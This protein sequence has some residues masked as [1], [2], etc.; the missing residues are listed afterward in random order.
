MIA[1]AAG[2]QIGGQNAVDGRFVLD[3]VEDRDLVA[4]GVERNWISDFIESG[5]AL[6]GIDPGA[7]GLTLAV[8]QTSAGVFR[9]TAEDDFGFIDMSFGVPVP[10]VKGASTL[11]N[12]ANISGFNLLT[13]LA[14]NTS[15]VMGAEFRVILECYPQNPDTSYPKL[16][17]SFTPAPGTTFQSVVLNL[18]SPDFSENTGGLTTADLLSQARYLSFYVYAGPVDSGTSTVFYLDDIA[19][20]PQAS[21]ASEAWELY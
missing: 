21:V 20:E 15:P 3:D 18:Q 6:E 13:F 12:P 17:W 19:L 2:A 4:D 5:A 16:Y 11:T 10:S 7:E 14:A 1:G 9:F 8:G